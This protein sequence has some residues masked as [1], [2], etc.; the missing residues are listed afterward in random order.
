M[1]N[2][3]IEL[4]K[5]APDLGVVD[6]GGDATIFQQQLANTVPFHDTVHTHGM[7]RSEKLPQRAGYEKNPEQNKGKTD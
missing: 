6:H 7:L 4:G 2:S 3:G 5:T 1:K